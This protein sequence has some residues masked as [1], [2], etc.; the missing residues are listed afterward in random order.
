[1]NSLSRFIKTTVVGG[2]FYLVPIVVVVVVLGKALGITSKLVAPMAEIMQ[3]HGPLSFF[4][5][6][7]L[8]IVVIVLFC[9]L[10]GLVSKT[11]RGKGF[12]NWLESNVLSVVP[13]YALVKSMSES[14][15]GVEGQLGRETVLARIEDS[16][17]VGLVVERLDNGHL[18]VYVSGAPSI[19]SG[20]VYFMAEDRIKPLGVPVA[21]AFRCVRRLGVGAN[22]LLRDKM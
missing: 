6:R 2:I 15:S 20:S 7:V 1:M 16:W 12:T 10:A 8:A 5:E 11:A 3:L 4:S 9:F 22:E 13:G 19:S 18:A 17:Q 14:M 21:A